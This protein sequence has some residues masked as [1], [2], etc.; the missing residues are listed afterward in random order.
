[1]IQVGTIFIRNRPL[2]LRTLELESKPYSGTWDVLHC[3][4]SSSLIQRIRDAGW[5]C[6]FGAAEVKATVLGSLAATSVHMALKD[7][8][9]KVRHADFNCLEVTKISDHRF[10]GMPYITVYAQSRHI[11]RG[12]MVEFAAKVPSLRSSFVNSN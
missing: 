2:I 12:S 5:N 9:V 7:I 10:F 4:R 8:F 11:Q 1:M 6:F 3:S